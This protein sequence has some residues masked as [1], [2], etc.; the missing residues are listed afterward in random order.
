MG[1]LAYMCI[2]PEIR[3]SNMGPLHDEGPWTY[4]YTCTCN[5]A[6]CINEKIVT[7]TEQ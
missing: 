3:M 5:R 4:Q 7:V 2:E 6:Q 1:P